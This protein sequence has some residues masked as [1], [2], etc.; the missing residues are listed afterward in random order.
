MLKD[1]LP[2][3]PFT[4]WAALLYMWIAVDKRKASQIM[5]VRAAMPQTASSRQLDR[6]P[7]AEKTREKAP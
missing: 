1:K 4:I 6:S 5:L 7:R 3:L 2:L